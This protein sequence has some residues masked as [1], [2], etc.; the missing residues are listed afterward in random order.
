MDHS[1]ASRN[2]NQR[3]FKDKGG[4]EHVIFVEIDKARHMVRNSRNKKNLL[5]RGGVRTRCESMFDRRGTAAPGYCSP[6]RN[7]AKYMY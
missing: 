3:Y 2:T 7:S 1:G 6:E 4:A 5:K